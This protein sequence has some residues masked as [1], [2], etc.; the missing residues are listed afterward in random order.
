[1][2]VSHFLC[3]LLAAFACPSLL[4]SQDEENPGNYPV[5][6]D[7]NIRAV[8]FFA[9]GNP[10]Q[11]PIVPLRKDGTKLD[12]IF[13]HLGP[14]IQNYSYLLQH[15]NADWQPSALQDNEF[16]AIFIEDRVREVFNSLNTLV[17]YTTYHVQLPNSNV[18]WAVS[19][20]YLLKIYDEGYADRK[21]VLVRRFMVVDPIWK[22][23]A[24]LVQPSRV[25]KLYSHH[26]I[27]FSVFYKD[28]RVATP[29]QEVKAWVLQNGRWDNALGLFAPRFVR[30]DQLVFDYQD[31]IIFPAGKEWRFFDMSAFDYRGNNVRRIY[32]RDTHYEVD[33][34][35]DK[36]R[37]GAPYTTFGDDLNGNFSLVNR[38]FQQTPN[39]SDYA[40]VRFSIAQNLPFDDQDV[41][42][43]GALSDWRI[44][45]ECRLSF[46]PEE[47][48]Y[49]G[50]VFLKQ[51]IYNYEYVLVD[52]NKGV[53]DEE[54]LEG[55]RFETTN[56]YT[57]LVYYRAFGERY[58]RLLGAMSLDSGQP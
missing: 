36:S 48:A 30:G 57:I 45:P 41:Y 11:L 33:L 2:P 18:G 53:M 15:C 20:N 29:E 5:V 50:Q 7:N 22:I 39:Q 1:M 23:R 42:V 28:M 46:S 43:F 51:G 24:D 44:N 25:D 32:E 12:L 37:N 8:S 55:N 9:Y 56:K 47:K 21:L 4:F 17:P 34:V 16:N 13:D 58:D 3:F 35:P 31:Q 49:V 10:Q 52:R 54:A 38:S 26:E 19:G 6:L 40:Y 27:D 14:E